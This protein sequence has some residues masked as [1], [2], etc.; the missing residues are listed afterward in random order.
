MANF[1]CRVRN[2]FIAFK[3]WSH[4]RAV[5][6]WLVGALWL[7]ALAAQAAPFA[8]V[9]DRIQQT[10]SVVDMA[11]YSTT[12]VIAME[13]LASSP[14]EVVASEA[15]G[16][17]WVAQ[18]SGISF[19]DAVSNRVTGS[20]ALPGIKALVVAPDGQKA[21]ALTYGSVAVIDAATRTVT[22][23]LA[24]DPS[25]ATLAIDKDGETVY[26]A[27]TGLGAIMKIPLGMPGIT[28]I[29][30]LIDE[31][32]RVIDTGGFRPEHLAVKPGDDR[33][34]ITGSI[35]SEPDRHA[36]T[37]MD[38]VTDAF[39]R[40]A[41]AVPST[42]PRIIYVGA[43]TFNADGSR[44]YIS[45]TTFG[46]DTPILEVDTASTLVLRVLLLPNVVGDDHT[47]LKMAT[48]LAGGKFVLAAFLTEHAHMYPVEPRRRVVFVDVASGAFLSQFTVS[49]FGDGDFLIGDI[50]DSA[51]PA[52]GRRQPTTTVLQ[53]SVPAPLSRNLPVTFSA[54]VSSSQPGG[55]VIFK[56]VSTDGRKRVEKVPVALAGGLATLALP[57]C[58]ERTW[59]S[60]TLRKIVCGDEF[61]VVA[62]FK[63]DALNARSKSEPLHESR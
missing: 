35:G 45:G 28:V 26:A 56:F 1:P 60:W 47:V 57:A 15:T 13:P 17:V 4:C 27:H 18:G 23:T 9:A 24:V 10:V 3:T 50:L 40:I 21:Y 48:S 11:S 43:M 51:A 20:L 32:D 34:Y 31:V 12:A 63:G 29:D 16:T 38:P 14:V 44:L 54:T 36:Y 61:K 19:I 55:K 52:T 6:R 49:N 62:V 25:A 7:T 42:S 53:A 39:T 41:L 33:L 22:A 46:D 5:L 37:V 59:S 58:T 8:Y 2:P 30:G